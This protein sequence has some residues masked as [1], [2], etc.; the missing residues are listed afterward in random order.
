M[1][2]LS[3]INCCLS[4]CCQNSTLTSL[5]LVY[6]LFLKNAIKPII[7]SFFFVFFKYILQITLLP[8]SQF[9]SLCLPWRCSLQVPSSPFPPAI[10]HPQFISMGHAYKF[11]GYSISY[12]VLT[13]PCLYCTYQF[14]L[15]PC[16]FLPILLLPPPN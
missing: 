3:V 2:F 10:P 8:L 4:W 13:S 5:S 6:V 12:T 11:F 15:N 7:F 1:C 16:I 14:V 9:L